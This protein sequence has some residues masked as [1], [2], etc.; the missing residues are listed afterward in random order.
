MEETVVRPVPLHDT[1][2]DAFEWIDVPVWIL[3]VD[4]GRVP[5]G[6]QA[7]LAMWSA[8]SLDE[9]MQRD[10]VES[11]ALRATLHRVIARVSAGEKLTFER[12]I[13]PRGRP[14]RM[15]YWRR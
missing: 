2:L 3:D 14:K 12:T 11:E 5:W 1:R 10:M 9:L 4:A 8:E 13:Y 7:S 15:L 6:N